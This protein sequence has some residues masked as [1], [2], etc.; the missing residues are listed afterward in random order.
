[1][2]LILFDKTT[3]KSVN[4]FGPYSIE[5]YILMEVLSKQEVAQNVMDYYCN[6]KETLQRGL[7]SYDE[8]Q[9]K[10]FVCWRFIMN[11]TPKS[12]AIEIGDDPVVAEGTAL[13]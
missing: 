6:H 3:K 9:G 5:Q 10:G 11:K 13:S 8:T 4:S 1:M 7:E 2:G 12:A